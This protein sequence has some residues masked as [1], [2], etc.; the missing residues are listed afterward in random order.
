MTDILSL[1]EPLLVGCLPESPP[2]AVK[3]GRGYG[4]LW[5]PEHTIHG[6]LELWP[7]VQRY[8]EQQR[9]TVEL[10]WVG[11]V[12]AWIVGDPS[13]EPRGLI[14]RVGY[15]IGHYESE[16]RFHSHL[17]PWPDEFSRKLLM[18]EPVSYQQ[19]QFQIERGFRMPSI[20]SHKGKVR[21]QFP[22]IRIQ[23]RGLLG[24]LLHARVGG[25]TADATGAD[26]ELLGLRG[27]LVS[28]RLVWS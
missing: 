25:L 5:K 17:V 15:K 3:Q 18:G 24:W 14:V 11:H 13:A 21:I 8:A 19:Y 20:V 16:D 1:L 7:Q 2:R 26:V 22:T 4:A 23:R 9:L 27:R 28:P 10:P 12:S 6:M